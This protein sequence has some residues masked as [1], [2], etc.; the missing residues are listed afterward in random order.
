MK[1][2][3]SE[4]KGCKCKMYVSN[5]KSTTAMTTI[6]T[7]VIERHRRCDGYGRWMQATSKSLTGH[8]T[9]SISER[10][11]RAMREKREKKTHLNVVAGRND[12]FFKKSIKIDEQNAMGWRWGKRKKKMLM[13]KC[14]GDGRLFFLRNRRSFFLWDRSLSFFW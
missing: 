14:E 2:V 11:L 5:D 1:N 13:Y 8:K 10:E 12:E 3:H 6:T 7:T 9:T 4:W